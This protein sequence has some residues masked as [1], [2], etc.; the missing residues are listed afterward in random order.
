MR[1]RFQAAAATSAHPPLLTGRK[2]VFLWPVKLPKDDRRPNSWHTSAAEGAT[3]AETKWTRLT[4]DMPLG[5]YQPFI[6][7]ASLGEPKWPEESW[8]EVMKIA[9][10][11]RLI[12]SEDHPVVRELL[13]QS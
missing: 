10:R 4:A 3:L 13:G 7:M 9:L 12:N 5:A 1:A 6:A 11:D 2:S 8:P